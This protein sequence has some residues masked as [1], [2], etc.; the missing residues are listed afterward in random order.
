MG[1]LIVIEGLDGAGKRTLTGKLVGALVEE[2]RTVAQRA[3]PRYGENVHADLVSDALHGGLGGLGAEVH[4]MAV[5]YALD[6]HDALASLTADLASHDVVLLD[7]YVASNAA[8]GAARLHQD[9]RGEFVEWVRAL[10]IDRFGLPVPDAHLLLRVPVMVAAQRSAH[11]ALADS[12]R[13]R[14]T[15]ETDGGLQERC[16]AVY[17]QLAGDGWLCP[18]HVVDG[19]AEPDIASLAAVLAGA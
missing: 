11:R 9:A 5:L 12:A 10:E 15:W 19:T 6:R 2:G 7:R 13:A 1:R 3:F 4:G 14:D 17:D 8:Y 18:W 16:A